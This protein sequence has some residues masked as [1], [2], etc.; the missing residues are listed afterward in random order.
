MTMSPLKCHWFILVLD[1]QR[2]WTLAQPAAWIRHDLWGVP[3]STWQKHRCCSH[4]DGQS[5]S[6]SKTIRYDKKGQVVSKCDKDEGKGS[7]RTAIPQALGEDLGLLHGA[8]EACVTLDV[9]EAI[10]T[11]LEIQFRNPFSVPGLRG[12]KSSAWS[13][14]RTSDG[15][16]SIVHDSAKQ[17]LATA[18]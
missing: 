1:F 17:V 5:Q 10:L 4:Q 16:C 8:F 3:Y 18:W 6:K 2:W 14:V 11:S 15:P 9:Y 12:T 13:M 7:Q